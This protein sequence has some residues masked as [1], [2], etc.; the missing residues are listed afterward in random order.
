MYI[1]DL[2]VFLKDFEEYLDHLNKVFCRI[3]KAN[4]KLNL[5]KYNFCRRELL[6]LEHVI[7]EERI[8]FDPLTIQKIQ[9]FPQPRIIKELWSFLGLARYYRKF[10]K[11]FSQITT[12]LFKLLCNKELF[13]WTINQEEAFQQI[14]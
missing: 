14:K 6:F 7:T 4:L 5:E 9:D 1:D 2:N 3:R 11:G 8:S 12:S 13:I 10:V